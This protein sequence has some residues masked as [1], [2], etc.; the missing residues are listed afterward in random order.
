MHV[1]QTAGVPP[2]RGKSSLAM[3]SCTQNNSRALRNIVAPNNSTIG[4]EAETALGDDA[5][6]TTDLM[7]AECKRRVIIHARGVNPCSPQRHEEHG[8][9]RSFSYSIP[10]PSRLAS[11]AGR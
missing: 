6:V 10:S 9:K 2:S 4:C 8:Y 5:R 11:A 3:I 1:V 7:R